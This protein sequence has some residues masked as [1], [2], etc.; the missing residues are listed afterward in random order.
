MRR[1][2]MTAQIDPPGLPAGDRMSP[3]EFRVARE[4]LGLT[5]DWL[6]RRLDVNPRTVRSWEQGRDPIPDGVRKEIIDLE[7]LT[8]SFVADVVG[9]FLDRPDPV[10]IT[11][12]SD[13]EYRR[14]WPDARFPAAWHRA[15]VARVAREVPGLAITY[16][17]PAP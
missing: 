7:E 6:A 1:A 16:E 5:G 11:Y 17:E 8:A 10:V 4:Y 9:Q 2:A 14:A 15:I 13:A 3:A 12:R